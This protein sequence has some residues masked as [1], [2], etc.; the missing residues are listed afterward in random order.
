MITGKSVTGDFMKLDES[1]LETAYAPTNARRIDR[2]IGY[3]VFGL[4]VILFFGLVVVGMNRLQTVS[5]QA[6]GAPSQT[7]A[8]P[9]TEIGNTAEPA[10]E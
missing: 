8:E 10:K 5:D 7:A 3:V 9:A 6:V 1:E 2:G 4:A